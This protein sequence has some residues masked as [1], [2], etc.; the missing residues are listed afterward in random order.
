MDDKDVVDTAKVVKE[1][2]Q[3]SLMWSGLSSC[4]QKDHI[5]FEGK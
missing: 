2:V 5:W 1:F 4:A 3:F